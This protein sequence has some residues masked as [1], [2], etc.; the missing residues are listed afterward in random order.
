MKSGGTF[1]AK[2]RQGG[3]EAALLSDMKKRFA[4]V[5][6]FKPEASRK[7]SAETYVVA[8]GFKKS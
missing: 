6:H 1:V 8:L 4:S 5:R 3:T 7:E 2:V